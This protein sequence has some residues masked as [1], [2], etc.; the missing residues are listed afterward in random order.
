[1]EPQWSMVNRW[2][3]TPTAARIEEASQQLHYRRATVLM[4]NQCCVGEAC[5]ERASADCARQVNG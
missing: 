5:L 4:P 2:V 1:M 3:T